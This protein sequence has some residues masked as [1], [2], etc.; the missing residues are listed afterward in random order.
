MER[1]L[2]WELQMLREAIKREEI[3]PKTYSVWLIQ[4]SLGNIEKQRDFS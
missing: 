1:K 2:I 3:W 4:C